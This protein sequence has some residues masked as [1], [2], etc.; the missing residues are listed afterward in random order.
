MFS[1]K[2][3]ELIRRIKR[4]VFARQ[5]V[6]I[7][8]PAIDKRY[9]NADVVSHDHNTIKSIPVDSSAD[10]L[11]KATEFD[12]IGIWPHLL[13]RSERGCFIVMGWRKEKGQ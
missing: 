10:I 3:E 4:A 11:A 7:F 2:T 9:S 12:V 1:G 13:Q 6:Q 5:N 8:K